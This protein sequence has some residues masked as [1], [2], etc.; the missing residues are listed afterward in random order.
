M[1]LFDNNGTI[2]DKKNDSMHNIQ[3][4]MM[5]AGYLIINL[6]LMPLNKPRAFFIVLETC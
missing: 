1:C 2:A 3:H 6:S 5:T 4:G